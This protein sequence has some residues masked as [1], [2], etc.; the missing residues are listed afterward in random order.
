M[1]KSVE[2]VWDGAVVKP[3]LR[4]YQNIFEID[5]KTAIYS[6]LPFAPLTGLSRI[7]IFVQEKF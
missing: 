1:A 7:S 2:Y 6:M 5:L 3:I 4:L